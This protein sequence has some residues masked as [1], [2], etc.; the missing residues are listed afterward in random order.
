MRSD[1]AI[2]NGPGGDSP[3]P[4]RD[5]IGFGGQY[6]YYTDKETGLLC[7]T[8][9][10]YDPGTGRFLN[11]DPIGYQGGVNL[12]GFAGGNP[13]NE[14]DPNGTDALI[15]WGTNNNPVDG[16]PDK[17]RWKDAA[18]SRADEYNVNAMVA[19]APQLL[20]NNQSLMNAKPI[21]PA[22]KAYVIGSTSGLTFAVINNA[23]KTHKNIDTIIFVGHA[24]H[25]SMC[26]SPVYNLQAADIAKLDT[27]NVQKNAFIEL[28]GCD[29]A[30]FT[31][32]GQVGTA[33][34][35]ANRFNTTVHEYKGGSSFGIPI[36]GTGWRILNDRPRTLFWQFH[37]SSEPVEVKPKH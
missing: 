1:T 32:P 18:E 26:V 27:S 7:L 37:Q 34:A 30:G 11:R 19:A 22:N 23:L 13:V 20:D 10:Y 3:I 17:F 2:V 21:P 15:F 28:D 35:F 24:S 16:I 33:Q 6:G 4:A 29:T 25:I 12:Y 31:M 9:R 36:P 8:H 5:P 14:S